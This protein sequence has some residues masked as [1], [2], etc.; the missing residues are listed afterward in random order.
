MVDVVPVIA[1]TMINAPSTP[2]SKSTQTTIFVLM[3][4]F[5]SLFLF[6]TIYVPL[7]YKPKCPLKGYVYENGTCH[8]PCDSSVQG[9]V[10]SSSLN[11]CLPIC[12]TETGTQWSARL[13]KCVPVCAGGTSDMQWD[14]DSGTCTVDA[15]DPLPSIDEKTGQVVNATH[16]RLDRTTESPTPSCAQ[17]TV[18]QMSA[19]CRA[20]G[21]DAGYNADKQRCERQQ[22]CATQPCDA[23]YCQ[24][25]T[26]HKALGGATI[27]KVKNPDNDQCI[28]P[29]L[30]TVAQ[31]CTQQSSDNVKYVWN[32]PRDCDMVYLPTSAS[33]RVQL[34][35]APTTNMI[36]GTLTH[37]LINSND[38]PLTYKYVLTRVGAQ[39]GESQVAVGICDTSTMMSSSFSSSSSRRGGAKTT[40]KTGSQPMLAAGGDT[41]SD[42][43]DTNADQNV[44]QPFTIRLSLDYA[45]V[46]V[47][48]LYIDGYSFWDPNTVMYTLAPNDPT[49]APTTSKLQSNSNALLSQDMP[50]TPLVAFPLVLL[51]ASNQ[52]G[53]TSILNPVLSNTLALQ[54]AENNGWLT[55]VTAAGGTLSAALPALKPIAPNSPTVFAATQGSGTDSNN[56]LIVGCTPA[57]C[58]TGNESIM[59]KM[60]ILAWDTVQ[61]PSTSCLSDS[62]SANYNPSDYEVKYELSSYY[63]EGAVPV[64]KPLIA[65]NYTL[66]NSNQ[67]VQFY[68]D[69]VPIRT[70][71]QYVLG[72]YVSPKLSSSTTYA[73]AKCKSQIQFVSFNTEDYSEK[74]CRS[75][76][77][78]SDQ[79]P[80]FMWRDPQ[81]GMCTWSGSDQG[82]Q[83]FYCF[84]DSKNARTDPSDPNTFTP[85]NLKLSTGKDCSAILQQWPSHSSEDDHTF[86]PD[87]ANPLESSLEQQLQQC[88]TGVTQTA[89]VSCMKSVAL[90]TG[91]LK[92]SL[93]DFQ[94]RLDG[95]LQFNAAHPFYDGKDGEP[96]LTTTTLNT[97]TGKGTQQTL[98]D[99]TY[100]HC[101]PET[102]PTTWGLDASACDST[103]T[104]CS[105]YS[106]KANC[107]R[108]YCN[109]EWVK[110]NDDAAITTYTTQQTTYPTALYDGNSSVCC[111]RGGNYTVNTAVKENRGSCTC[112]SG[113]SG[114]QCGTTPCNG[115]LCNDHGTCVINP[116]NG[117][118]LCAC[119]NNEGYY[120]VGATV[121]P[122]DR[123]HDVFDST[124]FRAPQLCNINETPA[125]SNKWCIPYEPLTCN[126]HACGA[127]PTHR[128]YVCNPATGFFNCPYV[129]DQNGQDMSKFF[130]Q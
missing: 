127:Q 44:T 50:P 68:V 89:K 61:V 31:L 16:F 15:C 19:L 51:P 18:E 1:P 42:N 37:P 43:S 92:L 113:H 100:N 90:E 2:M 62:D 56:V 49:S 23:A 128:S 95:A 25:P 64:I 129:L 28:N 119:D 20:G 8:P 47:Y 88:S 24:S 26:I 120:N 30:D 75:I 70:N 63:I 121:R 33:I 10:W 38:A 65:A 83:D 125:Q 12:P 87:F 102:M 13:K 106:T 3:V 117:E 41:G 86:D 66:Q 122:M 5:S 96:L 58:S 46:A 39:G 97:I 124:T 17:G 123:Q 71:V 76:S 103:D 73:T 108:N 45:S 21:W 79:L 84:F 80:P 32:P 59:Q 60:V 115:I 112:D 36:R 53:V 69:V 99:T 78:N 52:A 93:A 35:S 11:A 14:D 72:A 4:L 91:G 34:E 104:V 7:T 77:L 116:A 130:C 85:Q 27:T 40:K 126:T 6:V 110:T 114:V 111:N 9:L 29:E 54:L 118:P 107:D 94:A 105:F 22:D 74:F 81:S 98:W 48:N 82:A 101:G 55:Q 67:K 109:G 57:Y